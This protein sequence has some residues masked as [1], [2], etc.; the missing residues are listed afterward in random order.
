MNS[1]WGAHEGLEWLWYAMV[2]IDNGLYIHRPRDL[3]VFLIVMTSLPHPFQLDAWA[4]AVPDGAGDITL[5][6]TLD[7]RYRPELYGGNSCANASQYNCS[8]CTK[9]GQWMKVRECK[10]YLGSLW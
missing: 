2:I 6:F 1:T 5:R 7:S 3:C 8:L 4:E 9:G 10:V